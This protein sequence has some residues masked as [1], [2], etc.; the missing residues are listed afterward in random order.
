MIASTDWTAVATFILAAVTA[1]ST[2]TLG[3]LALRSARAAEASVAGTLCGAEV[4]EVR[5]GRKSLLRSLRNRSRLPPS[6]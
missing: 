5:R 1:G 6:A 2:V 3:F 4:P